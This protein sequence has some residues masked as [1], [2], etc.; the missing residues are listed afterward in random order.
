MKR[1]RSLSFLLLLFLTIDVAAFA[2]STVNAASCNQSDVNA[3]ING[4]T[5]IA[6]NGD[7]VTI[8]A[9]NCTWTSGVTV[10][11]GI[12]ISIIGAGPSTNI[13][14]NIPTVGP[15][16]RASPS[17]GN[18]LLRISSMTLTAGSSVYFSPI[19]VVGTCTSIGCPNLR[20]D[21]IVFSGWPGSGQAGWMIRSDNMFG[22]IDHNT[23]GDSATSFELVLAN[24]NNSAY[25]G[26]G[27]FGDNSWAQPDSYGTANALYLENNTFNNHAIGTDCDISDNQ[28]D[29]G[30]CRFVGRFNTITSAGQWTFANHGT[31]STG[32]PRGGRHHEVYN[33]SF[34]CTNTTNGCGAAV[35]YRSGTGLVF[36]NNF[37]VSGGAWYNAYADVSAYRSWASFNP[38]GGCNGE[39]PWDTDDGASMTSA[40]TFT[41]TA[42][43]TLTDTTQAW[44]TNQFAPGANYY[45]VYDATTGQMAGIVSNTATTLTTK[46]AVSWSVGDTYYIHGTTLYAS[47]SVS[48]VSTSGGLTI[49]DTSKSWTTNQWYVNG[50]S[51][52]L[53]DITATNTYYV[54]DVGWEITSSASDSLTSIFYTN[55]GPYNNVTVNVGDDYVVLR[56][57]VCLDQGT[58][59]AGALLSGSAPVTPVTPINETLDPLYEWGDRFAGGSGPNQAPIYASSTLK[60]IANRDFYNESPNQAAQTSPTSPFS[61][62]TGTGH[63]TL[64]NRP[65]TCTTG[66][67]YWATDQGSWNTSG[68]GGQGEL[69]KCTATNTW[70]L[71]YTP[72]TYPHPLITGGG[73]GSSVI[74]TPS[75]ATNLTGT[76][77]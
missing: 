60:M 42:S 16:F 1:A 59:G 27:Q 13:T 64:A 25:L 38:W 19:M 37:T 36:D 61:G 52:S 26:A 73:S 51:Y 39:S 48:S 6:V 23:I 8:P 63:G 68:S 72:Y 70:T 66:V 67:A 71:A 2:Q 20:V 18:S 24:I 55:T 32:R 56:A 15:A 29:I 3:V 31:E 41:A 75:P 58:R 74:Q 22:V 45:T 7:T 77:H 30:G 44:T 35:G 9:G 14:D 69:F 76:V 53:I 34:T 5:H 62:A 4:P 17:Y 11:G 50:D 46:N 65:T 47:G 10:P 43:T 40:S 28:G 57:S 49:I 33:N 12:G 54:G 21:N